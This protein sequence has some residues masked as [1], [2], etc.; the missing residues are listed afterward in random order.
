MLTV[1]RG[2]WDEPS[3]TG[4][5]YCGQTNQ[6]SMGGFLWKQMETMCSRLTKTTKQKQQQQQRYLHSCQ[7]QDQKPGFCSGMELHQCP[8]Q[9]S[10]TLL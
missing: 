1:L 2:I 10:F 3:H 6:Y 5:I 9:G 4:N 7:Q 8:Q